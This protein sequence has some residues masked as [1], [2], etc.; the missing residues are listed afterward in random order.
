MNKCELRKKY[1][2]IRHE[3]VNKEILDN[4]IFESVIHDE[5]V[6]NSRC[7]LLYMS[8]DDEVNTRKY[9]D[10]FSDKIIGIPKVVGDDIKFYQI[11]DFSDVSVGKFNILEPNTKTEI[12][13]FNDT[14]IIV[15][16]ICFDINR[17]RIGYGKGF[18]DRFL[19]DKSIY[20]IG[21][22]YDECLIS[23]VLH[24]SHD[25]KLCRVISDKRII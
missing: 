18:Y 2:E 17:Y 11:S 23:D 4:L 12:T 25:I 5:N 10:Y 16:G 3:I 20:S 7:I 24:D 9:I 19:C 14:V 15:P 1:K 13:S 8:L 21:I 22:C 6:I